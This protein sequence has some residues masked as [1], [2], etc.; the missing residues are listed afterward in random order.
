MHIIY[1]PVQGAYF[2]RLLPD[3]VGLDGVDHAGT[4][5]ARRESIQQEI[6]QIAGIYLLVSH[7][8]LFSYAQK[9]KLKNK[10]KIYIN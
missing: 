5:D 3:S 2:D 6:A 10:R 4:C 1:T 8:G 7:R 9:I